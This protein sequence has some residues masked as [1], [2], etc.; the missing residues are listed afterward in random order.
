MLIQINIPISSTLLPVVPHQTPSIRGVITSRMVD[1]IVED[2]KKFV[3]A[4]ADLRKAKLFNNCINK[5][6]L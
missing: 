5:P 4:G 2:N 3:D 1:S 6:F